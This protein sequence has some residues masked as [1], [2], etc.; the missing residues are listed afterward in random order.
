MT[1]VSEPLIPILSIFLANVIPI[2]DKF[3]DVNLNLHIQII[4]ICPLHCTDQKW[5]LTFIQIYYQNYPG[6]QRKL[7]TILENKV[8]NVRYENKYTKR[9]SVLLV[10]LVYLFS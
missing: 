3:Q 10:L 9:S 6:K 1:A 2:V 5:I 8:H 4:Q 7:S